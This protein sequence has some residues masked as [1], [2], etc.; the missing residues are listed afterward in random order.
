MP[1]YEILAPMI[2]CD[3]WEH[4]RR[5]AV[6]ESDSETRARE[7]A[8]TIGGFVMPDGRAGTLEELHV[9]SITDGVID[10]RRGLVSL[11]QAKQAQI[12]GLADEIARHSQRLTELR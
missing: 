5:L 7:Y 1:I 3:D 4:K 10:E 2:V 8:E 9:I 11:I 6:V 12:T